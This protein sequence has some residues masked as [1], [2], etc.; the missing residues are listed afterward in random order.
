MLD[1]RTLAVPPDQLAWICDP[2]SLAYATSEEIPLSEGIIGQERAVDAIQ[3]GLRMTSKGYNVFVCGE[4]GTGRTTT[5]KH[6][7]DTAEITGPVLPDIV[8]VNNFRDADMPVAI[9]LPA[10]QGAKLRHDMQE[11]I[12][13]MRTSIQQIFESDAYKERTKEVIERYKEREKELIRQLE[14]RIRSETF[15]LIQVQLGP[16]SKPEIAPLINGEPVQMDRLDSLSHQGKFSREEYQRL[17]EKAQELTSLME[18]TF[19]QARDL[20]RG[21]RAELGD[22]EKEFGRP[23]VDD[24]IQDLKEDYEN[25]K[26][27]EYLEGV[28]EQI[29]THMEQFTERD[30]EEQPGPPHTDPQDDRYLQYQVNVLVD[31]SST[32]RRPVILETAPNYRNLF[33]TIE[34]VVDRIGHWRS[35]FTHIKAGSLLRAS[36]GFLVLNL[37]DFI[38]E[39]GVWSALKRTL[40]NRQVDIQGYDPMNLV[41]ISALKPEPIP[42]EVR[43][44]VIGDA[45]SYRIL[46]AY[47]P[48]FRK[49]FKVK[50]D[51][52]SV[53]PLEAESIECYAKFIRKVQAEE[54]LLPLDGSAIA[55][56][57]ERGVRLA[58][59]RSKLSTRFS[60][61][62]DLLRETSYWGQQEGASRVLASHVHRAVAERNRRV[63]LVED[64]VQE[65]IIEGTIL[66]D[67]DGSRVGQINGLS[68]F[69]LGDTAFGRPT[70]IT[71]KTSVGR[72][73]LI[74]IER[75]AD[76]S[77]RSHNKGVL[78]IEGL[79]REH[80]AKDKP[81][82]MSASICFE[83]SYS[84]V[85][86]DSASSTEVYALLSSLADAPIRQDIAV[87][88]SVNQHGEIQP[89]GGV[90]E[91]IEGFFD[92]C[93]DRGL[94]GRQGVMI[95]ALN[96]GDLMLRPD[97]VQAVRDGRF[98][99]YAIRTIREGIE[100][101]TGLPAGDRLEGDAWTAGSIFARADERLQGFAAAMRKFEPKETGQEKPS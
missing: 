59:R 60:E 23:V 69:D 76:L 16:F 42:V 17:R 29:L 88:G 10:G 86:G 70:R 95:P 74:N 85:D 44:I 66:I 5:V 13:H 79:L 6:L 22:L 37:Y 41:S 36:G 38:G 14:E 96:L 18:D 81:I 94:T 89:I 53:M 25:P 43:V 34:K 61:I 90:N 50:S 75:E 4:P 62:A 21:L 93:K 19:R 35:D 1:L 97:V 45:Y 39:P 83:Q 2:A 71:A 72:A 56:V 52:D 48:D 28:R 87:T 31:N 8:Y 27:L 49:I 9:L 73:G 11:L 47:D 65:L 67:T 20:K 3:I 54:S 63:G 68:V 84:G 78:I 99:V 64:K 30:G 57:I 82:T 15:A 32:T 12:A 7:L 92:V 51:F 24:Y 33:G 58:G 101:L 80:F 91:K 77:G 100:I 46:Y 26:V 98:Y 55:A 40:K